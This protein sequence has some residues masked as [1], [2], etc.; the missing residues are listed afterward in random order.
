MC[1]CSPVLGREGIHV[2]KKVMNKTVGRWKI[3]E[4]PKKGWMNCVKEDRKRS[5]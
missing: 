1:W 5:E 2:C 4:R 3:I